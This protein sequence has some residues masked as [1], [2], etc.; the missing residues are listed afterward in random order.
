[1]P[2][3]LVTVATLYPFIG[4][5]SNNLSEVEFFPS[6]IGVGVLFLALNLGLY[7]L[8]TK[9]LGGTQSNRIAVV[10]AVGFIQLFTFGIVESVSA[11]FEIASG[12]MMLVIWGSIFVALCLAAYKYGHKRQVM[13][14]VCVVAGGLTIVP[15]VQVAYAALLSGID[16]RV[17][18]LSGAESQKIKPAIDA[19]HRPNVYWFIFDEYVRHDVLLERFKFDNLGFVN[20]LR[21]KAFFVADNSFANYTSTKISIATTNT[22]DYFVPLGTK[23]KHEMWRTKL[24]G[25][26]TVVKKFRDLGYRYLHAGSGDLNWKTKCGGFEDTCIEAQT[27]SKLPLNEAYIGLLRLTPAYRVIRRLARETFSIGFTRIADVMTAVRRQPKGKPFYLFAHI[28]SPHSPKRYEE[29]CKKIRYGELEI[30]PDKAPHSSEDYVNDIRCLNRE[31]V[32]MVQDIL[33]EDTSDPII[34]IQG[35][36][37]SRL[38][39]NKSTTRVDWQRR[40]VWWPALANLS[41]IRSPE[42][43]R[44]ALYDSMSPVNNFRFVFSC[45]EKRPYKFIR[46]TKHYVIKEDTFAGVEE[47]VFEID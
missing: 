16:S 38:H 23:L 37:G 28:M 10:M 24:R 17:P 43:C 33:S 41:A 47:L 45:I 19:S 1:M 2:F 25:Q 44:S 11:S 7:A 39:I 35:D 40:E 21:S 31:I 20:A 36:H 15:T 6:I 27:K 13:L 22:M 3:V 46:D 30:N 14:G 9:L 34:I 4:F 8:L 29:D 32:A 5:L 12:R 18:E 42:I 26:S